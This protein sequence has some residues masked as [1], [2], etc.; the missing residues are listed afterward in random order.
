MKKI[1]SFL[2]LT[3]LICL[4]LVPLAAGSDHEQESSTPAIVLASFG[5]TV[6]EAVGALV[7]IQEKVKSAFPGV[8]VK[9]TF[10]SSIIRKVWKERQGEAQVWLDKGIPEEILYVENIFSTFGRL[11]DEGDRKSVV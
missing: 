2:V 10:T 9:I 5:T 4:G 8:P 6:P 7:H 3:G 1:W 11:L